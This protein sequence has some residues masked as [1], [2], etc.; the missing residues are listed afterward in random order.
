MKV[1]VEQLDHWKTLCLQQLSAHDPERVL[2]LMHE[3]HVGNTMA[4]QPV[5]VIEAF[6]KRLKEEQNG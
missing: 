3:Q 4:L 2:Q 6:F 1:E 5:P